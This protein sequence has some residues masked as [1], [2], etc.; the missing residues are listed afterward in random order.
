MSIFTKKSK[1][2]IIAKVGGVLITERDLDNFTS[3]IQQRHP[4][5]STTFYDV[6]SLSA[7]VYLIRTYKNVHKSD[8]S[9]RPDRSVPVSEKT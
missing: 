2:K 1:D 9:R 4:N 5:M 7:M 3:V 8:S 6:I